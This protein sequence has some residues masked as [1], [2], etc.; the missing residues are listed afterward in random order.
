VNF[1]GVRISGTAW[2]GSAVG[3]SIDAWRWGMVS[4]RFELLPYLRVLRDGAMPS[5]AIQLAPDLRKFGTGR[6]GV[7]AGRQRLE[8]IAT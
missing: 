1:G 5:G 3:Y 4:G 7:H 2:R 6:N 8:W